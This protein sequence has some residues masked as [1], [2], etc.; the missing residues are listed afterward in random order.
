MTTFLRL[1][2]MFSLFATLFGA[3]LYFSP[4]WAHALGLDWQEL[5]VTQRQLRQ[6]QERALYL[7]QEGG[8]LQDRI[9]S[10]EEVAWR[11]ADGRLSLPEAAAIFREL[12]AIPGYFSSDYRILTRRFPH[13]A[14]TSEGEWL[15]R[16]VIARASEQLARVS[17]WRKQALAERLKAELRECLRQESTI[18]LPEVS[19]NASR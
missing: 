19:S 12:N 14:R 7:D 1:L 17:A 18:R 4:R 11:V 6:E 8:V 5:L 9:R 3:F 16:Q 10:K 15:C 13:L 2:A